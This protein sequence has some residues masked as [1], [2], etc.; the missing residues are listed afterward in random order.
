MSVSRLNDLAFGGSQ[1]K[2]KFEKVKINFFL[3]I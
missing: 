3:T 1:I 2:F